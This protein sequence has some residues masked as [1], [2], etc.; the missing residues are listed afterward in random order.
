[1]PLLIWDS[2][3]ILTFN[4]TFRILP[5]SE[6]SMQSKNVP[7]KSKK[8]FIFDDI[9]NDIFDDIFTFISLKNT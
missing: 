7:E 3:L 4:G 1:L 8:A 9:F 6:L 2:V 5:I